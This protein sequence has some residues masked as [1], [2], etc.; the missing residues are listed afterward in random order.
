MRDVI[1]YNLMADKPRTQFW[2]KY[3]GE[4]TN[5]WWTAIQKIGITVFSVWWWIAVQKAYNNKDT[6]FMNSGI[7][8]IAGKGEFWAR[9]VDSADGRAGKEQIG[10]LTR[11]VV[12]LIVVP[13]IAMMLLSWTTM[14]LSGGTA[15]EAS[16]RAS[17]ERRASEAAESDFKEKTNSRL[18]G[19]ERE[20]SW[21]MVALSMAIPWVMSRAASDSGEM[22][23]MKA[24][25]EN[26]FL[27]SIMG[28]LFTHD[29]LSEAILPFGES[30]DPL[31]TRIVKRTVG[32]TAGNGIFTSPPKDDN[33]RF[34]KNANELEHAFWKLSF[35]TISALLI[36]IAMRVGNS[37]AT[38]AGVM[39]GITTEG[40]TAQST[41]QTLDGDVENRVDMLHSAI[42]TVISSA[43]P[44]KDNK[45]VWETV[46]RSAPNQ[47]KVDGSLSHILKAQ[48][49]KEAKRVR[50]ALDEQGKR[51]VRAALDEQVDWKLEDGVPIDPEKVSRY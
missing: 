38:R 29:I 21:W 48:Q 39:D 35:T 45:K 36:L 18:E 24:L 7:F 31:F 14:K 2:D 32:F 37:I 49:Y 15:S 43:E 44:S 23:S 26:G 5:K 33:D 19:L 12:M 42:S 16:L 4:S 25:T 13:L 22:L 30:E 8:P 41:I 27:F 46:K 28:A 1:R 20:T 17:E 11:G 50:A 51:R 40:N 10:F 47:I 6:T 34:A 9:T 3:M